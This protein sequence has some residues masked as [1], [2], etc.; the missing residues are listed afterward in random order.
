[1]YSR[2]YFA[3]GEGST[4]GATTTVV[5]TEAA[6]TEEKHEESIPYARFAEVNQAK[7]TAEKDKAALQGQLDKIA[8][9]KKTADEKA[10]AEQGKWQD[11]ATAKDAELKSLNEQVQSAKM[12]N[13]V[14]TAAAV[15]GAIDPDEVVALLD[16]SKVTIVDGK[17][18]GVKE[19]VEALLK[20]KPH[21]VAKTGSGYQMGAGGG[22]GVGM[23]SPEEIAGYT[24][25]QW[26]EFRK[27]YP[28]A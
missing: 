11:I 9:D 1:M 28:D 2:R 3:D 4:A 25:E 5:K 14:L 21:L 8:S 23:P 7:V 26:K 19:A 24:P 15:A 10:L 16:K 22:G 20:Q 18:T 13:A 17:V 12:T 27:K 6:G